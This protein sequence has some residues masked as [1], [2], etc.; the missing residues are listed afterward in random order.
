MKK[1]LNI[2]TALVLLII[3]I[4]VIYI[5]V[6]RSRSTEDSKTS[7]LY[8]DL[9]NRDV[10]TMTLEFKE[11][12]SE[13]KLTYSQDKKNKKRTQVV[14][15]RDSSDRAKKYN[16]SNIKTIVVNENGKTHGYSISYDDKKYT[17]YEKDEGYDD[18]GFIE[19]YMK[20]PMS[21][22]KYYTKGYEVKDSES[23]FVETFPDNET[24]YYYEGD[25]LK[26]I[27]N[28]DGSSND[29]KTNVKRLHKV[30][31]EN[32]FVEVSIEESIKGLEL[33]DAIALTI[34]N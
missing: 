18:N 10:V 8:Y 5:F 9:V 33:V 12:E 23:L 1:F 11:N 2:R 25:T 29:S 30:T 21:G 24:K 6:M 31:I 34:N 7:K 22:S 4:A 32:K 19:S 26:Y 13:W 14:E 27:E 16:Q 28:N 17:T 3:L 20:G 15:M